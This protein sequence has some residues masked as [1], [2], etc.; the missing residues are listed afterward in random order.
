MKELTNTRVTVEYQQNKRIEIYKEEISA[1]VIKEQQ[2]KRIEIYKEEI[3][4]Y[5][6]KEI[7]IKIVVG[8]HQFQPSFQ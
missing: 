1:Y 2:N 7:Q 5:V 8:C 4:A 6:I 3:S